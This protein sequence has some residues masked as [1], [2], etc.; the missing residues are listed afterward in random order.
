M[1]RTSIRSTKRASAR[2]PIIRPTPW[3]R[4]P[5]W[6]KHSLANFSSGLD[7]VVFI[8]LLVGSIAVVGWELSPLPSTY[9]SCNQRPHES[10]G[11]F[12]ASYHVALGGIP[13]A[14]SLGS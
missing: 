6:F 11:A 1:G 9:V 2:I 12:K 14:P 3:L 5:F 4:S 13:S 7:A 8:H 10:A